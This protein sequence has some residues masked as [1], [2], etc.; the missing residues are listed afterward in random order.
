[1][2]RPYSEG[3][4]LMRIAS[5][6][7]TD[8]VRRGVAVK[9]DSMLGRALDE[10]GARAKALEDV[11]YDGAFTA[12]TSHDGFLP[13]A[14]ATTT[15]STIE[16]GTSIAVA[17]ART[18]MVLAIAANDLQV[19]SRGR[20]VLG[21]GSQIKP[22]IERR[23]SMPWSHPAARMREFVLAMRAIWASWHDETKLDFRGD[24]YTH[25]LMTPF[26]SPGPSEYGAPKVWLAAVGERMTEVAGEVADGMIVHAFTTER[27][28]REV[29]LPESRPRPRQGRSIARQVRDQWA[30]LH[31]DRPHRREDGEGR[32][33][34]QTADR[35]LRLDARVPA[36]ARAARLGR[37]GRRAQC[38]VEAG[39]VG[40]DGRPD[41]RRHPR[42]V[43]GGWR[44][45]RCRGEAAPRATACCST[46]SVTTR[47]PAPTTPPLAPRS[48]RSRADDAQSRGWGQRVPRDPVVERGTT[49][50]A[51]DERVARLRA[52]VAH[53]VPQALR[54]DHEPRP[55]CRG[56]RIS[57][58]GSGRPPGPCSMR[59]MKLSGLSVSSI[60]ERT[61][62]PS[63]SG[64]KRLLSSRWI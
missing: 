19:S 44:T 3:V 55:R 8:P 23:F 2:K 29:T 52:D 49:L 16:L 6:T 9:V 61:T 36:C 63:P 46:G 33:V 42:R 15:T 21:L 60:H 20:F 38:D 4:T 39:A 47:H 54:V 26:F 11:G 53:H 10:V 34:D 62:Q 51:R 58:D 24:F 12:E 31:R 30:D 14:V 35:V 17:F 1:M 64:L 27:Y 7:R 50:E 41:H 18:P 59:I 32:P 13:L 45:R 37:G 25:T 22:H 43:R 40:R 5:R 28:L 57:V 56:T 48:P